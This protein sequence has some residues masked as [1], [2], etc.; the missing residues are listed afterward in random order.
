[1]TPIVGNGR[2]LDMFNVET[3]DKSIRFANGLGLGCKTRVSHPLWD[4]GFQQQFK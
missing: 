1:M 2:I 3:A 4:F